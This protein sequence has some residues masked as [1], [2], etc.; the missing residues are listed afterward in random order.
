MKVVKYVYVSKRW[1]RLIIVG[2]V[3]LNEGVLGL[4]CSAA[5]LSSFLY[6]KVC[7]KGDFK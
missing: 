7:A 6:Y 3:H 2:N 1:K 5:V 4:F